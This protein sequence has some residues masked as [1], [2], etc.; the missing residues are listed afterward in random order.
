[1][2]DDEKWLDYISNIIASALLSGNSK[3]DETLRI[4]HQRVVK[5]LLDDEDYKRNGLYNSISQK[6]KRIYSYFYS[7]APL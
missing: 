5:Q 3:D 4:E 2:L 7:L 6:Y 1:M